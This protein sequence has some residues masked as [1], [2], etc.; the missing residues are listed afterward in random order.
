MSYIMLNAG[1]LYL[2]DSTTLLTIFLGSIKFVL[3]YLL[4]GLLLE[5][6]SFLLEDNMLLKFL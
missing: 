6:T 4:E 3:I 5:T 2:L 1:L